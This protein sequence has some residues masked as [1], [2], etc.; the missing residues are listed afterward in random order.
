MFESACESICAGEVVA[1]GE[2]V[3][4][5]ETQNALTIGQILF[6]QRDGLFE[7]TRILV[8]GCEVVA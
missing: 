4:V 3:G 5:V 2:G 7:S 1:G 6:E 8:G